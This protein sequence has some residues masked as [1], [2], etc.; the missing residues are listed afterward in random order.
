MKKSL[1]AMPIAFLANPALAHVDTQFH[2]H[3]SDPAVLLAAIGV[4]LVAAGTAWW[5]RTR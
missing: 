1:I 4:I 2:S 3:G 5:G